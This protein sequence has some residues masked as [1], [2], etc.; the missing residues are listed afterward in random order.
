MDVNHRLRESAAKLLN[1]VSMEV[2]VDNRHLSSSTSF[3]WIVF[4]FNTKIQFD[5]DEN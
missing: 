3:I 1:V 2:Y 5:I 4:I